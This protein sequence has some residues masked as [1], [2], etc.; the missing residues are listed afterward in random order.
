[1]AR[2]RDYLYVTLIG[3]LFGVFAI[4]IITNLNLSFLVPSTS[5]FVEVVIL[6][7][8][9]APVAL[10]VA[11]LIARII[12]VV[13]Q[14]AKFAAVGA[15]NTFLDWGVLNVLIALTGIATGLGYGI[16]KGLSFIIANGG[17]YFWNKYW[18][19]ESGSK[20][21]MA[22][23]GKFF[24]VSLVG[25]VLNV[26]IALVVVSFVPHGNFSDKQWANVGA[27]AATVISLVWNFVGYKF[28]VFEKKS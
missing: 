14:L 15:F 3:F 10:F 19:F 13:F 12:P 28:L 25:L 22:E 6:F 24:L 16:F 9:L 8:I 7:T 11:S 18:T 17:S 23:F 2:L 20:A 21:N 5:L 27:A 4:P 1:M 26:A